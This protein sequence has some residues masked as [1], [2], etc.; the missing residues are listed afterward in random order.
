M[1]YLQRHIFPEELSMLSIGRALVKAIEVS[2]NTHFLNNEE[3]LP[4]IRPLT[5][6]N[7]VNQNL[8]TE[9]IPSGENNVIISW[10]FHFEIQK[11]VEVHY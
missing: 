7:R 9:N 2:Q 6:P 10:D 8:Q 4:G 11:D 5:L 3:Q 1:L